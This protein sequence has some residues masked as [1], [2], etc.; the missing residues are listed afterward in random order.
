MS[1]LRI[2]RRVGPH[3]C[4]FDSSYFGGIE[5]IGHGFAFWWAFLPPS[6]Y[7]WYWNCVKIISL[8]LLKDFLSL[9]RL[10]Y[11]QSLAVFLKLSQIINIKT[12]VMIANLFY[13][14]FSKI[15]LHLCQG[16]VVDVN[17]IHKQT[18]WK[19]SLNSFNEIILTQCQYYW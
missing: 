2:S 13:K 5:K 7:Q 15:F 8:E 9:R 3:F 12:L 6:F 1:C 11:L 18:K 10:I 4:F 16:N 17:G 14:V 19:K